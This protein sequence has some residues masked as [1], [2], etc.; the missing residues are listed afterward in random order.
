MSQTH[1]SV[2]IS[3]DRAIAAFDRAPDVMRRYVSAGVQRGAGEIASEARRRAPKSLSNLVNSIIVGPIDDL[4]YVVAA[5]S[6]HAAYVE[7][8]SGPAAGQEKYYPN[9]DNLLQYLMTSPR[10]RGFE[11]FK[12]SDLGRLEQ[13]M[14]LVRRAQSFAWWIYQH[15]TRAQPF[16]Q[17]AAEAKRRLCEEYVLSGV[18]Q[19]VI[20]VFGDGKGGR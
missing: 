12:R 5:G 17:P 14:S 2:R 20:A 11:R 19:G 8:G 16:M 15:G 1:V 7:A 13:E 4:S 10:A 3:S 9:P 6:A 18:D